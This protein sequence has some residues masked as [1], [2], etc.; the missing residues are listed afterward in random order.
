MKYLYFDLIGGVS[1]DMVVAGLLDISRGFSY[2]K[3]ELKKINLRDYKLNFTEC[4]TG[5]IKAHRFTVAD[6]S[7]RKRVFQFKEIKNKISNSRLGDATKK[8]I[9]DVYE[10]LYNA[11]KNVHGSKDAHFHQVGEID[12]LIDIASSCILLDSLKID[13]ILY[14]SIPFGKKVS[15]AT[16]FM[17]KSRDV[18]LSQHNYENITPTGIAVITTLGSHIKDNLQYDFTLEKI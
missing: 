1:G 17:L 10:V 7:P 15:P 11:E 12:S 2:L 5:G 16:A 3:N 18:Y 8:K 6:L 4:K 14:S 9:L 13:Y